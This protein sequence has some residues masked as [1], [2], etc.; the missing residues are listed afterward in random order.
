[1]LTTQLSVLI[2]GHARVYLLG[3][4]QFAAH[5]IG[6]PFVFLLPLILAKIAAPFTPNTL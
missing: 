3:G 4:S 2:Y 5:L 1:L 6:A